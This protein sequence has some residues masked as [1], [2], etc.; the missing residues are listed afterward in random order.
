L[1]PLLR[2]A[3]A[4][5][6]WPERNAAIVA[7]CEHLVGLQNALGI[8][9]PLSVGATPFHERPFMVIQSD[10]IIAGLRE[11]VRDPAV[12]ALFARR[13][14]GGIDQ[15]SDNTDLLVDVRLRPLI[16]ALFEARERSADT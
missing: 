15:I 14:L 10:R 11:Q 2:Q 3:H 7:A 5:A 12:Q 6:T 13:L 9:R 4:A 16:R 1:L 8:T